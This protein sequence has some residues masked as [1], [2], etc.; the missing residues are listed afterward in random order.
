LRRTP[1]G[2]PD[3]KRLLDGAGTDRL[4]F[5]SCPVLARPGHPLLSADPKKQIELFG[6]QCV[7][8]LE[9][10][11]E[12]PEGLDE[13]ASARHDLGASAR[14]EIKSGKALEDPDGIIGAQHGYGACQP[15]VL[16]ALGSGCEN[17]GRSGDHVIRPMMLAEAEHIETS[18]IGQLDLFDEIV[19]PLRR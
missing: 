12:E 3:R 18:L 4:I 17:H 15:D 14:E 19:Q 9:I 16:R 5:E 8:I 6:E 2:D 13:G 7:V 10:M 11:A 1:D